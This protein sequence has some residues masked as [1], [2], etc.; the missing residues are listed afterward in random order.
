MTS[1]LGRVSKIHSSV[2]E[3]KKIM[4]PGVFAIGNFFKTK[5][6]LKR[7]QFR[8]KFGDDGPSKLRGRGKVSKKSGLDYKH[9]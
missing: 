5:L 4:Q 8:K 2:E 6:C 3:L 7:V 1:V 9:D